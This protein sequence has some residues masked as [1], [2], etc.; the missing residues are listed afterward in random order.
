M[1]LKDEQATP[2]CTPGAQSEHRQ[3]AV[4]AIVLDCQQYDEC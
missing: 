1:A 2:K 3:S 4:E